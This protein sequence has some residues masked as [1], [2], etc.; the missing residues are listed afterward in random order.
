MLI[1]EKP[2]L[3]HSNSDL[4]E[5]PPHASPEREFQRGFR[6]AYAAGFVA[7]EHPRLLPGECGAEHM[8]I[9]FVVMEEGAG[10]EV[11]RACDHKM[12]VHDDEFTVQ[13]GR[14][15]FINGDTRFHHAP[16]RSQHDFLG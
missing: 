14:L 11:A 1:C 8:E 13:H 3:Q 9:V 16:K 2:M 10:I 6:E 12:F 5:K 15:E 7:L 4:A